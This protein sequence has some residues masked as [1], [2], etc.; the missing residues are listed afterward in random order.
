MLSIFIFVLGACVGS[1]LNV[2]IYRIP[3]GESIVFPRSRCKCGAQIPWFLNI[4]LLSWLF[5]RGRAYCCGH[6]I[7]AR[8]FVVEILT[9]ILFVMVFAISDSPSNFII[10]SGFCSLLLAIAFID[11]DTMEIYDVMS[12]GGMF[13]GFVISLFFPG[14]HGEQSSISSLVKSVSGACLGSG[15]I[16]WM[17]V[18]GEMVFKKEA[19][20]GGDVKLLGTIGAFIGWKGCLFSIFG[21]CLISTLTFLPLLLLWKLVKTKTFTIPR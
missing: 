2:C 10:G 14:W 5:L 3:Q 18:M 19:I 1:F 7:P 6:N 8:Y 11:M 12:V 13:V 20:G 9:A 15:L 16:F 17:A 4:P 21:G